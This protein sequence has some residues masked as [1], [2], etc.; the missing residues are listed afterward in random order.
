[1]RLIKVKLILQLAVLLVVLVAVFSF[2]SDQ[3]RYP[4]KAKADYRIKSKELSR[5]YNEDASEAEAMYFEKVIEVKGRVL[6]E[7]TGPGGERS[8]IL[9]GDGN[10]TVQCKLLEGEKLNSAQRK[11][12]VIKGV[13][14]KYLWEVQ[15]DRCV[16]LSR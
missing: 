2:Y 10:N 8:I 14:T 6:G 3:A 15:L 4:R 12:V 5:A 11:F 16:L 13:C 7:Q 9:E 1:M